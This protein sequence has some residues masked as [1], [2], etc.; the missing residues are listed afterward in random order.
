M[1]PVS[2]NLGVSRSGLRGLEEQ[3]PGAGES[4][5]E[6]TVRAIDE[7][8]DANQGGGTLNST[9]AQMLRL[10]TVGRVAKQQEKGNL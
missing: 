6:H 10:I 7:E 4:P 8:V 1:F 2:P 3:V 5:R 9:C